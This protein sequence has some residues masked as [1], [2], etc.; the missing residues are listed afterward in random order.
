MVLLAL[1]AVLAVGIGAFVMT[2]GGSD[3]TLSEDTS[4]VVTDPQPDDTA[5]YSFST[6]ATNALAAQSMQVDMSVE[7]PDG[8]MSALM[9]VDRTTQRMSLEIDM[10]DMEAGGDFD[11]PLPDSYSM[12]IDDHTSTIYFSSDVFGD[13]FSIDTPWVV[14]AAD[15]ENSDDTLDEFFSNP[16]DV[17]GYFGSADPT[18]LGLEVIDGEELNHFRTTVRLSDLVAGDLAT[19]DEAGP[20]DDIVYDVWVTKDNELRRLAF[21]VEDSGESG[22][23]VMTM[24][25]SPDSV[26]IVI[27]DPSEVTDLE[28]AF[29]I[30]ASTGVNDEPSGG[31]IDDTDGELVD[32]W[33][34]I[35]EMHLP[36]EE[37]ATDEPDDELPAVTEAE[38]TDESVGVGD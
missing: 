34:D 16:F 7:T 37:P 24:H 27:P 29:D 18:D 12:I 21:D 9:L 28:S 5:D 1:V 23:V 19:A 11:M 33:D 25:M 13:F 22:R 31:A 14:M 6:A 32:A 10:S 36:T 2:R 38:A 3:D 20:S 30:Q 35:Q 15:D 8:A 4:A 26:D 17:A